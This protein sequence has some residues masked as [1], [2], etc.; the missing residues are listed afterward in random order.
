[1]LEQPS[2]LLLN[3]LRHNV[4]EDGPDSVEALIRGTD[5]VE[6]VVVKQNL[7]NDEDRHSLA[8]LAARLHDPEAE[9]NDLG[10]EEEVDNLARVVLDQS[11]D[12]PQ[13]S[14]S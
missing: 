14:K 2:R 1:M 11:A 8:E 7:L 9:G 3:Q 5:V 4:A 10:R 6:P 13:R 12:D